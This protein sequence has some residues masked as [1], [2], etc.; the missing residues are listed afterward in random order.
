M[1][2][3]LVL[4]HSNSVSRT[5]LPVFFVVTG[6]DDEENAYRIMLMQA[7]SM[8]YFVI[9]TAINLQLRVS[10]LQDGDML[11]PS[12]SPTEIRGVALK[13]IESSNVNGDVHVL[14]PAN[15]TMVCYV[16]SVH[17]KVHPKPQHGGVGAM[18]R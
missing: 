9:C 6:T 14:S 7:V 5:V 16:E 17:P 15:V 4:E 18:P 10:P 11:S 8:R 12:L 2:E 3:D 13:E 1:E